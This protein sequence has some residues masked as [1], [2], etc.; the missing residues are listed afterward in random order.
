MIFGLCRPDAIRRTGNISSRWCRRR[1]K[2]LGDRGEPDDLV[3]GAM[4]EHAMLDLAKKL[5]AKLWPGLKADVHGFRS[6]LSTWA[7]DQGYP[8]SSGKW[9]YPTLSATQWSEHTSD[10]PASMPAENSCRRG[11]TSL[12]AER[13]IHAQRG[14]AD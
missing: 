8:P 13:S 4:G 12:Q 1:W 5:V 7:T 14:D 6:T 2:L 3:F 10:R 11:P 9:H